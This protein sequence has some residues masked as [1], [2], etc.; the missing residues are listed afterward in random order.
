MNVQIIDVEPEWIHYL[1]FNPSKLRRAIPKSDVKSF[2]YIFYSEERDKNV[3][4]D[5][6]DITFKAG[7]SI[8]ISNIIQGIASD[9]SQFY[10]DYIR[11]LFLGWHVKGEVDYYFSNVGAGLVYDRYFSSEFE[12]NVLID[13]APGQL[14]DEIKINYFGTQF[15]YN[16]D[17]KKDTY[18]LFFAGGPGILFFKN[19]EEYLEPIVQKGNTFATHFSL[20]L[21]FVLEDH[22][23]AGLEVGATIGTLNRY[24]RKSED[25]VVILN[26]FDISRINISLGLRYFK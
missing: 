7:V 11:R 14:F 17:T 2:Q 4:F 15:T 18:T 8:G 23:L 6:N 13:G 20:G 3:F 24:K 1:I 19:Y 5:P 16:I 12:P 25:D 21:D 10:Q 9:N 26:N 22:I